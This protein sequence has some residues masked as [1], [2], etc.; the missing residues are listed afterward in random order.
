MKDEIALDHLGMQTH[1]PS[2]SCEP[3]HESVALS[4]WH[5]GC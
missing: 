2:R 4:R 1:R 3:G 5:S